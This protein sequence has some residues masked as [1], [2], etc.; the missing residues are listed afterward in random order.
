MNKLFWLAQYS[1]K[2]AFRVCG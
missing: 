1:R 2:C